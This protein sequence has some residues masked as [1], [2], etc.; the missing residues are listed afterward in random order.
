MSEEKSLMKIN[1]KHGESLV[2]AA[3][4]S[5]K[6]DLGDAVINIVKALFMEKEKALDFE[7]R[8][9]RCAKFIQ[10]RIDAIEEGK[11]TLR[12]GWQGSGI[13]YNDPDLN[14]NLQEAQER[15]WD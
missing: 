15:N 2:S 12:T 11:F 14:M 7:K 8:N 13:I 6:K 4:E 3:K 5:A 9:R 1:R 10:K